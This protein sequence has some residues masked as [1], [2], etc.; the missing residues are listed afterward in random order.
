MRK[1]KRKIGREALTETERDREQMR[2]KRGNVA[3]KC[4]EGAPNHF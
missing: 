1:R 2:V 3:K 4:V